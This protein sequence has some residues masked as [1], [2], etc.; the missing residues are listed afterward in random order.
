MPLIKSQ[1]YYY[2]YYY[3]YYLILLYSSQALKC[4]NNSKIN[5]YY[6][7]YTHTHQHKVELI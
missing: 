7:V 4:L 6:E 1:F 5:N 3:Y 2:Y